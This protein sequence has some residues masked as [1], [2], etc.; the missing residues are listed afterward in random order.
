M[1]IASRTMTVYLARHYFLWLVAVM[2]G[3][4]LLVSVFD[5]IELMRRA[6]GKEGVGFGIVL[7]MSA[8]KMPTLL[9]ELT[10]FTVLLGTMIAFWRLARMNELVIARSAGMSPWQLVGPALAIAFVMGVVQVAIVNPVASSL[11]SKFE[12]IETQH[13]SN[14]GSQLSLS[15][16]GFWLR[17]KTNRGSNIMHAKDVTGASLSLTTVMVLRLDDAGTLIERINARHAELQNGSWLLTEAASLGED[18][19]SKRE[20]ERRIETDMSLEDVR[21]SF[22][23]AEAVSFWDL[24][25][26]TERLQEA[27]FNAI[28]HRLKFH[29]L[30]STPLLLCAM[31][32][33]AAV[34]SLRTSQRR[35]ASFLILGGVV[36][37]FLFFFATQIVHALGL[38]TG[39]PVV[40]A[41]WIPAGVMTMLGVTALLHLEDG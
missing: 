41:A 40:L 16:S 23:S 7:Q 37:G 3:F 14:E 6:S 29:S 17:E 13:L 26:F 36:S 5:I 24:P 9:Q 8:L 33:V 19:V 35:G 20:D 11:N 39:V 32:L 4:G 25:A 28:E 30:L 22:A 38:S 18:G 21:K 34:F 10:P 12:R 31:V 2:V 27:G 15:G 1:L